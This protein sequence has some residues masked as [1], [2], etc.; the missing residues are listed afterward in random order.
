M[1]NDF[2]NISEATLWDNLKRKANESLRI[3]ESEKNGAKRLEYFDPK[4]S[5]VIERLLEDIG[6]EF[7]KIFLNKTKKSTVEISDFR[8]YF[9]PGY[10]T[11]KGK[12]IF[13]NGIKKGKNINDRY[14]TG[15]G[16]KDFQFKEKGNINLYLTKIDTSPNIALDFQG[17][18]WVKDIPSTIA[19]DKVLNQ[20][21][22]DKQ[23][24]RFKV[25]STHFWK[26]SQVRSDGDYIPMPLISDGSELRILN[27]TTGEVSDS[28]S[29]NNRISIIIEKEKLNISGQI[30]GDV[31]S[32]KKIPVDWKIHSDKIVYK[33]WPLNDKNTE[34]Y[35][36]LLLFAYSF[37]ISETLDVLEP[38]AVNYREIRQA[39]NDYGFTEISTSVVP[40]EKFIS[41]ADNSQRFHEYYYKNWYTI[42][43]ES[44]SKNVDL[45]TAMFLTSEEY[46]SE[47]LM[48][49]GNWLRWIY[50]EL[51]ILEATATEEIETMEED[52]RNIKHH[53]NSLVSA[54]NFWIQR[55]IGSKLNQTDKEILSYISESMFDFINISD[56]P[57][58]TS[59]QTINIKDEVNLMI[60]TF[61][62]LCE[63]NYTYSKIF[64]RH[65]EERFFD[66]HKHLT[67]LKTDI[68]NKDIKGNLQMFRL[69]LKDFIENLIIHSDLGKPNC[70]IRFYEKDKVCYLSFLNSKWPK[71]EIF[72]KMKSNS[73]SL[74]KTGWRSINR[75]I[76]QQ[77]GW[78]LLFPEYNKEL[79]KSFTIEVLIPNRND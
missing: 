72:H 16:N 39:F 23:G 74:D 5:K 17:E 12:R 54:N 18:F 62:V 44:Y 71:E 66:E 45:G 13:I 14:F 35:F 9:W 67:F 31:L 76:Q 15:I 47:F 49:C 27:I 30:I 22:I 2:I 29:K 4:K 48:K 68:I 33:P 60:K 79:N 64:R 3:I 11:L 38:T 73:F 61:S 20:Y 53:L 65:I 46:D 8:F 21:Y 28:F 41:N 70:T 63:D 59:T 42:F 40:F 57:S 51:R 34:E 55:K 7:F 78:R 75:C 32:R 52:Y 24:V 50:N 6:K 69:M 26:S 19:F 77:T 37:W 43:L 56:S 58:E 1:P 10:T 36:E 25:P